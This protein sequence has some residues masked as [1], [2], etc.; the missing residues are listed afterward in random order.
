MRIVLIGNV[1]FSL[2]MLEELFTLQAE[3]VGVVTKKSSAFNSDFVDLGHFCNENGLDSFHTHN[4][5]DQ[6]TLTWIKDRHPDIIFC[7]GHSSLLKSEILRIAPMGVVGFHPALLPA[8]RGRHPIIWAL[9]VGLQTTGATF[10]F[11]DEGAD[12]GPILSQESVS[13]HK[14]DDAAS[15]YQKIVVSGRSQVRVF[16][17]QLLSGTFSRVEQDHSRANVWRK[18]SKRDGEI[19]FRMSSRSIYNLV[20][21]LTRPYVGAH[22]CM[23]HQ[24]KTVDVKVWRVSEVTNDDQNIEPGRVLQ[25]GVDGVLVKTGDAAILLEKADFKERPIAGE[26]F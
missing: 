13:I 22:L 14:K 25:S 10:F 16:L 5:N 9:A 11:M 21:A 8:N 7:F 12:S 4:V 15:L 19:D 3:I 6:A 2:K 23:R 18:R 17:P 26:Y 20:R 24:G 1:D